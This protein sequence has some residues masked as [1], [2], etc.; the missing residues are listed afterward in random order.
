MKSQQALDV[1]NGSGFISDLPG[2]GGCATEG[3]QTVA[4]AQLCAFYALAAPQCPELTS[5]LTNLLII[6]V[7]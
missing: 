5:L 1:V 6:L 4:Q 2:G 7:S 3:A